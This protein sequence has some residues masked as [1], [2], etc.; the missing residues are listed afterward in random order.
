MRLTE[1]IAH[2]GGELQ[3]E[4]C[5]VLRVASLL[6]ADH[7]AI[8]FLANLK[9]RDHLTGSQA[10]AVILS[11]DMSAAW[12]G[13]KI[14]T[15][16]PYLYFSQLSRLLNPVQLARAGIH[17]TA[18]VSPAAEIDP[19]AEIGP[20]VVVEAEARIASGVVIGA[21]T[22]IGAAVS[23]GLDTRLAPG[24][25]IMAGCT[26]GQRCILHAGVV[27]GSDGFGFAKN[28]AQAWEKIPQ[29]GRV[30]IGDDVEIG[31]NTTIDRGALDDTVIEDGV[32]LDN[33][34][35]IAHN[36]RIGAHSALAG[37]VG[38]AG[39]AHIGRYCTVGGGAVILGHLKLADHVHVSANTLVTKSIK[40][41]GQYS[42]AYP[43]ARHED[44]L[45][46]A[47]HLRGLNRLASRIQALW[48]Q[49]APEKQSAHSTLDGNNND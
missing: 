48:A 25:K 12:P 24:V 13:A 19:N 1:I 28:S 41:A 15:D 2:L 7:T 21:H 36:V 31:A 6:H 38:V 9:Y 22:Y 33:Q 49:R 37:C 43:F 47:A 34:I 3:G 35:Q 45:H 27:I 32:K 44:W 14:V 39:S 30:Q 40:Q 42:G 29:I 46:N 18:V 8:G 20:F 11:P 23:I 26:I 17:A 16:D 5:E 10:A 4:D